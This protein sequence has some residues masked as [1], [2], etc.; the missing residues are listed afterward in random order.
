MIIL[1]EDYSFDKDEY[2]WHLHRHYTGKDKKTGAPKR[3]K[4][5]TYH[6]DLTSLAKRIIEHESGKCDSMKELEELYS[7]AINKLTAHIEGLD[8]E[9]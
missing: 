5:T 6:P 9:E 3:Q 8:H 2:C 1:N 4:K 7:F